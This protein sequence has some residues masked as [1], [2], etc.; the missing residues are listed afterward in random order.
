MTT[1]RQFRIWN[2]RRMI[3]VYNNLVYYDCNNC[4]N[5]LFKKTPNRDSD[6]K[7]RFWDIDYNLYYGHTPTIIWRDDISSSRNLIWFGW[8]NL[9]KDMNSKVIKSGSLFA[10]MDSKNYQYALVRDSLAKSGGSSKYVNHA[11]PGLRVD[12]DFFGRVRSPQV[13]DIGAIELARSS[14]THTPAAFN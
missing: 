3:H 4:P 2:Q 6:E 12:R 8:Q 10:D 7:R 5:E 13:P 9:G 14:F 1:D 11:S